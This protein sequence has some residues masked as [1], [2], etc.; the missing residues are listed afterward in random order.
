MGYLRNGETK[1]HK[2]YRK[3]LV[4]TPVQNG[5]KIVSNLLEG[6]WGETPP[7]NKMNVVNLKKD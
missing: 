7:K 5:V 3:F 2:I 4:H 1:I 6:G